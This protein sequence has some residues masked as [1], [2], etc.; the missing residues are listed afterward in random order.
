MRRVWLALVRLAAPRLRSRW[1]LPLLLATLGFLSNLF[2][3]AYMRQT[4]DEKDHLQYGVLLAKG[5]ARKFDPQM[6]S[7]MPVSWLNA[8]PTIVHSHLEPIG[9]PYVGVLLDH[10]VARCATILATFFF[11]LVVFSYAQAFYGRRAGLLAQT[12]FVLSPN[13]NA[14][15]TLTTTDL[16]GG[17]AIVC[18]LYALH[19]FILNP[20][21]GT[22]AITALAVAL[23]QL[24]KFVSLTLFVAVVLVPV[25]VALHGRWQPQIYKGPRLRQIV[26]LIALTVLFSG[27][28]INLAFLVYRPLQ[29][30]SDYQFRSEF[31]Q[32]VQQ[33]PIL[34]SIPMPLPQPF[35]QGLDWIE[36][37]EKSG[38]QSG[39]VA[40]LGEV[41]GPEL[42][43]KGGFWHYYLVAYV[44][45]T[46]LG[47]QIL[48]AA[49]VGWIFRKRKLNDFLT[50]EFSLVLVA[51]LIAIPLSLDSGKQIG[52]RH[53]LPVLA[54]ATIISGAALAPTAITRRRGMA[55][56]LG[57]VWTVVS[58]GSY[59][60]HLIPYFNEIV[61]DRK[62]AYSYLADSNLDWGQNSRAV[63]RFLDS[64]PE[65]ALAPKAPTVGRALFP[66]NFVAG[67]FPTTADH[68]IRQTRLQP[69]AHVGYAHLLFDVT[70]A[71]LDRLEAA[72]SGSRAG[73]VD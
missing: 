45:K 39:N 55:V 25:A 64:N 71:D 53:I 49:G 43:E 19:R 26:A 23:A 48:L 7:K 20:S 59:Y 40:L 33:I 63:H 30:L 47:M 11:S 14:H 58:V 50:H 36:Y 66:A 57:L 15:G 62:M 24:T 37:H 32:R 42:K 17:L 38:R 46:P 68:W 12:L 29:P 9:L 1:A 3:A 35:V 4:F 31:F 22:A 51:A 54:I 73:G 21:L 18:S 41:R 16:Y 61:L 28:A 60:P 2:V 69:S 70:Q 10:R 52:V 44:L 67:V 72:N 65:V 56:A 34:R 8:V 13:I 5:V 27:V 6:D